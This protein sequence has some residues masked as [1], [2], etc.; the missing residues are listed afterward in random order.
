MTDEKE[1]ITLEFSGEFS[2][3]FSRTGT[4][5]AEKVPE[6][7]DYLKSAVRAGVPWH[8]ALIEAVGLWTQPQE[9]Y[10][11]RTYQ[12]LIQGEAFDWLLLAERLCAE[13][14]GAVPADEKERLLFHGRLPEEAPRESFRE[15]MGATKHR[16]YLNYWYGVVVEEALQLAVEE[17]VRK[18]HRARCYPDSEDFVEEAFTHLY[19]KTR[20]ELL[21]EFRQQ[22]PASGPGK[23]SRRELRLSLTELKEFTYWLFKR[24][25]SMWD[26]ARVA[27][28]TRK[29]IR[30]LQQLE[31]NQEPGSA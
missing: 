20:H 31:E 26:P 23:K 11:G 13:L 3:A 4:E 18:R 14:D 24:R 7:V 30:R 17:E 27:S 8:Q 15:L 29:G 2:G 28:D 16:A 6:A 1:Q 21:E 9:V 22:T 10:Q 5:L 25:I 19:G 12:Y